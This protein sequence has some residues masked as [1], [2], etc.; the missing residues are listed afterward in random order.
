M[1]EENGCT[2]TCGCCGITEEVSL[3]NMVIHITYND[4]SNYVDVIDMDEID[5][6]EE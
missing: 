1:D 4:N 3:P 5:D 6:S 2:C